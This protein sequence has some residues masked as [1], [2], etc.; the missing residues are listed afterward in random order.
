MDT[1]NY[2]CSNCQDRGGTVEKTEEG[3]EVYVP[4]P[5]QEQRRIDRL[6]KSS[7]ISKEFQNASFQHFSLKDKHSLVLEAYNTSIKYFKDFEIIRNER[8][9]SLMLLGQ[10]GSGKT[11]LLTALSNNLIKRRKVSLHY[12]RYVEGFNDLKDD[13]GK[14]EEKMNLMKKVDVL[15]IDDLFK[16]ARGNPRATEWQIEQMYAVINY[17]YF[18][19]KPI[20]ISSELTLDELVNVDEALG[21]R[22]VQMATDKIVTIKGDPRQLNHRVKGLL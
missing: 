17:R 12:F 19:H 5:C 16:P 9:N 13:F 21:T 2:H 6:F 18:A 8:S 14:L 22:L 10:P 4:C 1:R 11:H 7:G 3:Y 20:L 15:F